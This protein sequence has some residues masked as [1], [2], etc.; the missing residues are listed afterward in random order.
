[1]KEGGQLAVIGSQLPTA[2]GLWPPASRLQPLCVSASLREMALLCRCVFMIPVVS[3]IP[4][5]RRVRRP[6]EAAIRPMV[7]I[8][9]RSCG[10]V[11]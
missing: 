2:S 11:P 4:G 3:G 1:M 5:G 6:Y 10:G 8:S 7:K 9:H